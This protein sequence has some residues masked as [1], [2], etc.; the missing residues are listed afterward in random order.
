MKINTTTWNCIRYSIYAPFYNITTR[1]FQSARKRTIDLMKLQP[2]ERVLIVGVGTGLDFE[3]LPQEIDITAIDITPAMVERAKHRAN[4][5]GHSPDIQVM[6]AEDMSFDS[7]QFDCV[8]LH[9]LLAVVPDPFACAKEVARVLKPGG[10]VSIFDKFFPDGTSP[11]MFR[12]LLNLITN[13]FFSN[14]NRHLG[15]ILQQAELEPKYQEPSVFGGA[16]NITIA[17]KKKSSRE[18]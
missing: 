7:E 12:H 8:L 16:F 13:T 11:S 6:D 9:L 14:I 18:A 1:L 5:L 15:P 10:R 2:G 4:T 3:F 17:S